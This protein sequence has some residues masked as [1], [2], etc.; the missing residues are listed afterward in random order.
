MLRA[1]G[2]GGGGGGLG[3]GLAA[4]L[5]VQGKGKG[6]GKGG[7]KCLNDFASELRVW[8]GG[9][10]DDVTWKELQTHFE[11]ASGKKS[12]WVEIIGRPGNHTGAVAYRT[13]EEANEVVEM[14]DQSELKG[15]ILHCAHWE[16]KSSSQAEPPWKRSRPSPS[17]ASAN[18]H[19][20][21]LLRDSSKASRP[22]KT[23]APHADL[24]P[25]FGIAEI[26][27]ELA[28]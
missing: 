14:V 18:K 27:A 19:Q 16:Q 22:S 2:K 21:F 12:I 8:V 5:G 6:K 17:T 1:T 10:A 11:M 28:D 3:G 20:Q 25:D 15:A 7:T 4:L 13:A 26:L 24:L 9:L 23:P